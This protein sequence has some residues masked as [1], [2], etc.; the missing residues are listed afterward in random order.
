MGQAKIRK[1]M[2][3]YPDTT[4]SKNIP[5]S[6][7]W[8]ILDDLALHSKSQNVILLLDD[9]RKKHRSLS[10]N[11]MI[12]NLES[13]DRL[14]IIEISITGLNAFMDVINAFHEIGLIDRLE[15]HIGPEGNVDAAF[16]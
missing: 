12:V 3:N 9:L 2:G 4:K 16:S 5:E 8:K 11:T 13:S 6:I 15:S 10:G 1:L 7:T 14:P